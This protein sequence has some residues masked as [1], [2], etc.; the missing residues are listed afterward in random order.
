MSLI[1]ID[2]KWKIA[3]VIYSIEFV[4]YFKRPLLSD[5]QK[6]GQEFRGK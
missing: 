5:R 2:G 6:L 1:K 4:A 3:S